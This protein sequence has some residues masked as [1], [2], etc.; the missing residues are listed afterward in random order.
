M[1]EDMKTQ[2]LTKRP[3]DFLFQLA[4]PGII[5]MFVI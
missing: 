3:K 2:L 1:K 5:G 4:I